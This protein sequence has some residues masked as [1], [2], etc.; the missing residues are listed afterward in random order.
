MGKIHFLDVGCGDA[1]VISSSNSMFLVD[2]HGIEQ[3]EHLL[4]KSKEICAVFVTHQHRDHYGGLEYLRKNGYSIGRLIFSPYQR[5]L[6]RERSVTIEEWEEF[7]SHCEYFKAKGT[8]LATPY[9]QESF[10]SPFWS[11]DGIKFWMFGPAKK[12]ANSIRREIHDACLVFRADLGIRK[13]TFT[14]DASDCTLNWIARNTSAICDDI[15]LAS[16]HGYIDGADSEFVKACN[17]QNCI[18]STRAGFHDNVPDAKA[19]LRYA[20]NTSQRVYRTDVDGTLIW[21]F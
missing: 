7:K 8:E 21:E 13:V 15:L 17:I 5:R 9:R 10:L 18:I 12:I 6:F 14:G 4:P 20:E 16:H 2:C 1:T 11:V 3:H 19:L